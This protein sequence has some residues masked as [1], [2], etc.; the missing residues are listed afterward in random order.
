MI[1]EIAA[2]SREQSVGITQVNKAI[3]QMD[4][5]TQSN[6]SLVEEAAAASEALGAQAE[7]LASLVSFF[8]LKNST[9][10]VTHSVHDSR[11]KIREI[12]KPSPRTALP[13]QQQ[14]AIDEDDEW[15][16]F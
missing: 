11:A 9:K 10:R 4:E 1:A 13:K 3:L 8:K 15:K 7:E 14:Q 2:A 5:M 12:E 6:A 16:D